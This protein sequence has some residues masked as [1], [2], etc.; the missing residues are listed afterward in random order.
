M[1]SLREY[2]ESKIAANADAIAAHR[3]DTTEAL[4]QHSRADAIAHATGDARCRAIEIAHELMIAGQHVFARKDDIQTSLDASE[5]AILK[6][7]LSTEK[8]FESVNEFRATLADQQITL[9]RKSEVEI[10]FEAL[11]AKLD[12]AVLQLQTSKGREMGLA[13]AAMIVSTILGLIM[14]GV[15][16]YISM[17]NKHT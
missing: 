12:A 9:V 6:A 17:G 13:A 8:R 2:L 16:L 3:V 14:A 5:K 11:N 1:V 7:E 15:S 10:R 4:A